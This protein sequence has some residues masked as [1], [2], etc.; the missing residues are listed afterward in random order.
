MVTL[1]R[2]LLV[3]LSDIGMNMVTFCVF[4]VLRLKRSMHPVFGFPTLVRFSWST[5]RDLLEREGAAEV[6]WECDDDDS[7]AQ[8]IK[9]MFT[10][11]CQWQ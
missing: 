8:D 5:T 9:S 11:T 1:A 4:S 7:S 3:E 2:G 6:K 10:G